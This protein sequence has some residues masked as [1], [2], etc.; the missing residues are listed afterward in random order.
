MAISSVNGVA[1]STLTALNGV[2][3]ATLSSINGQTISSGNGLLTNLISYW[4]MDDA[5]GN[6]ADAHG[7]NTLTASFISYGNAG[8][9]IDSLEFEKFNQSRLTHTSN[10]DLNVG[11]GDFSFS[12]WLK[13]DTISTWASIVAKQ[14]V[15]SPYNGYGLFVHPTNGWSLEASDGTF[16]AATA[17]VGATL[18]GNWH[19]IV[20]TRAGATMKF[21]IDGSS[22]TVTGSG[23]SGSLDD[24][25]LFAIGI[26]TDENTAMWDGYMDECGFWKRELSSTDV[27]ALYN[28]GAALAYGSFTA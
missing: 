11:S 22:V 24:S 15:A 21:Y 4:K 25:I 2:S 10:T 9:I 16:A 1:L 14:A 13:A 7:S 23:R 19:H 17:S 20:W 12:V 28:G 27:T 3:K 18:D 26:G 5:S 8:I 6:A